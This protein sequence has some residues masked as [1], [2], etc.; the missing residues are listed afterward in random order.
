MIRR[1]STN[2]SLFMS[3][4]CSFL[5]LKGLVTGF[6]SAHAQKRYTDPKCTL[7]FVFLIAFLFVCMSL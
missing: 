4:L 5:C 7:H 3:E 1:N 6:A 2:L